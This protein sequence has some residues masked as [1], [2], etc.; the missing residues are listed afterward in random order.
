MRSSNF[1]DI[2]WR[3][4]SVKLL[5]SE[6]HQHLISPY[7]IIG[8][9][10]IRVLRKKGN[11]RLV[12]ELLIGEQILLVSAVGKQREQYEEYTYWCWAKKGYGINILDK[13]QFV[14]LVFAC[15]VA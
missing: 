9:S 1:S 11:D 10:N 8:E 5:T 13:R 4:Q 6:S 14:F 2:T 7:S 3:Y 12:K 15:L